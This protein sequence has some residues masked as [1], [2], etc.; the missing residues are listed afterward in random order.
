[1]PRSAWSMASAL[2]ACSSDDDT[3]AAVEDAE[4]VQLIEAHRVDESRIRIAAPLR[5]ALRYARAAKHITADESHREAHRSIAFDALQ[6]PD[7]IRGELIEMVWTEAFVGVVLERI[8]ARREC[9]PAALTA[10]GQNL[11][12]ASGARLALAACAAGM[13]DVLLPF[14]R[15]DDERWKVKCPTGSNVLDTCL[16]ALANAISTEHDGVVAACAPVVEPLIAR[17][18][19]LPATACAPTQ[20]YMRSFRSLCGLVSTASHPALKSETR[21]LPWLL[22]ELECGLER[23]QVPVGTMY[24]DAHVRIAT[25]ARIARDASGREALARAG[26]P[27][28]L[29]RALLSEHRDRPAYTQLQWARAV[30]ALGC[31]ASAR[32]HREALMGCVRSSRL[33]VIKVLELSPALR[34][35]RSETRMDLVGA[36]CALAGGRGALPLDTRLLAARIAIALGAHWDVARV[37]LAAVYAP[38]KDRCAISRLRPE[39]IHRIMEYVVLW[40]TTDGPPLVVVQNPVG[41]R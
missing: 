23:R 36:L 28:L 29:T 10:L 27:W 14:V 13:V 40:D 37:L 9:W 35:P 22:E 21:A 41:Q 34:T 17:L 26:A 2:T 6:L 11:G 39:N 19:D 18:H 16:W 1:M 15:K 12:Y 38:K 5:I 20:T 32:R 25:V 4:V 33:H 7:P 3:R 31:F 30:E 8:R 24:P